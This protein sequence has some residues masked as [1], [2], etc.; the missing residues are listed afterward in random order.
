MSFE[1]ARADLINAFE[2][3]M[4]AWAGDPS[5]LAFEVQNQTTLNIDKQTDPY[6]MLDIYYIDGKQL[7]IGQ[8]KVLADYGQVHLIACS[9]PNSG[10]LKAA[11]IL[12]HFRTYFEVKDFGVARTLA[13]M[14][15][16]PYTKNGWYC[17]PLIVPFWVQRLVIG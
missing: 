7:S 3:A 14:S 10:S 11:K 1:L 17:V 13:S 4:A 2:T 12:D 9:P 6:L 16:A 15:A 8:T 5:P